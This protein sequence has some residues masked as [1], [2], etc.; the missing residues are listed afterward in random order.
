MVFIKN[1]KLFR[2]IKGQ[3][4]VNGHIGGK[5]DKWQHTSRF[6][7]IPGVIILVFAIDN[8]KNDDIKKPEDNMPE[9]PFI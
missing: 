8:A 5:H 4:H 3:V 9:Y 6:D 2:E 1:F 7:E